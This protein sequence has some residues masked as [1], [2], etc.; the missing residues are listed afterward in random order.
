[1]VEN[2]AIKNS[3]GG[4]NSKSFRRRRRLACEI[5]KKSV[6]VAL[7]DLL[8]R[9]ILVW[10]VM[11]RSLPPTRKLEVTQRARRLLRNQRHSP[12]RDHGPN[13][14]ACIIAIPKPRKDWAMRKA[15]AWIWP[16]RRGRAG[17]PRLSLVA[18][19]VALS[20]SCFQASRASR[21]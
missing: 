20:D 1:M 15:T 17:R 21:G 9:A 2:P 6:N 8:D 18:V 4:P 3:A 19:S 14:A 7:E 12:C 11:D 13:G 5:V 10:K 16:P